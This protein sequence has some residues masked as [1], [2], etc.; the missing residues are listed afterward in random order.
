[1]GLKKRFSYRWRLFIP[2]ALTMLFIVCSLAFYHY[3]REVNYRSAN[4]ISQLKL[5]ANR[6]IDGYE[7]ELDLD[8]YLE[9][10]KR[11]YENNSLDELIIKIYDSNDSLLYSMG[12]EYLVS[13]SDKAKNIQEFETTS[14][15][16]NLTV[17]TAMPNTTT[18]TKTVS[19]DYSFWIIMSL[20]VVA[21]ILSALISTRLL[22]RNVIMLKQFADSVGSNDTENISI[23]E[24]PHDELGDISRR[25]VQ[26]YRSRIDSAARSERDHAVALNAIKEKT[27]VKKQLTNNIN[28]ELKTPIGVIKGYIET[29]LSNPDMDDETRTR[30]LTRASDNIERL[31]RLLSDVSEITRLEDGGQIPVED[32][33]FHELVFTLDNDIVD[34]GMAGDMT[35][36]YSLPANCHV[37][38]NAHLLSA[39]LSNLV[40]NAAIHSKGK[41]MG[42][43]LVVETP[44]F[45]T[46]AFYDDGVGVNPQNLSRIFERF[47]RE[48]SGRSR[49]VGGTGLGLPI[50]KNTVEAHGGTISAHNRS[51]GGLEFMFT[52]PK[53]DPEEDAS[54]NNDNKNE[55]K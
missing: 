8:N 25:I 55:E 44:R 26:L 34:A 13:H 54:D 43:R 10:L 32:V 6:I 17:Y 33:D 51:M 31:V 12:E 24:F 29:I 42:L 38:G 4:I 40:K 23:P 46:F 9:F 45:Y 19:A 2:I 3:Q 15:D 16:G 47:Y 41:N 39:M 53:W 5:T 50:V 7:Q 1:M 18:F 20:F 48:D 21:T 35:F 22:S 27:M 30:F 28:H 36:S 52:L 11:Y 49:K 14:L 37:K